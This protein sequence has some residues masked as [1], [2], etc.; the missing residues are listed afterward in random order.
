MA[1]AYLFHIVANHAFVD[2]NK[3]T[4]FLAMLVFLEQNGHDIAP[5]ENDAVEAMVAV[6]KGEWDVDRLARWLETQPRAR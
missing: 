4:A 2:G 3:R 1:A 6:A 5:L